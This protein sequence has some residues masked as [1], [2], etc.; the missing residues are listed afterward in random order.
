M[1]SFKVGAVECII[2]NNFIFPL[3]VRGKGLI[4][5]VSSY[6][7]IIHLMFISSC[8]GS[9]SIPLSCKNNFATENVVDAL[10]FFFPSL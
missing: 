3:D 9:L 2:S 10:E 5:F 6:L 7:E 8:R 1:C 4:S